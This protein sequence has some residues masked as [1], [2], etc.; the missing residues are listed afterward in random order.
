MVNGVST[1]AAATSCSILLP[2]S[3]L[4]VYSEFM[5]RNIL[6]HDLS[7]LYCLIWQSV[8]M[9]P[10][11]TFIW[12]SCWLPYSLHRNIRSACRCTYLISTH[13][14]HAYTEIRSR[15]VLMQECMW[16]FYMQPIEHFAI[17]QP[18]LHVCVW[19]CVPKVFRPIIKNNCF[20]HKNTT[21]RAFT[22]VG[23]IA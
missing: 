3:N 2:V 17:L 22:N 23:K 9:T 15:S 11:S 12:K 8:D 19:N 6:W 20:V 14:G 1:T 7:F 18:T 21:R 4:L 13:A 5:Y 10:Y 16:S